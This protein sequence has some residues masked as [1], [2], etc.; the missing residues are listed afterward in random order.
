MTLYDAI[1]RVLNKR[2]NIIPDDAIYVGRPT[3]WGN[4]FKIGQDGNRVEVVAKYKVHI[5]STLLPSAFN[6]LEG[7]DLV[8]WCAPLPCHADILLEI[9][10]MERGK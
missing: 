2:T 3:V 1:P 5:L 7:K 6:E 10:A 4:P 8:C 9:A